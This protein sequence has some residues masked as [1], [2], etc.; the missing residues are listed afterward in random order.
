MANAG[1]GVFSNS[2]NH[3]FEP[4]IPL[5]VPT[6]NPDHIDAIPAQRKKYGYEGFIVT[7][8]NCSST[9]LCVPLKAL[10]DAFGVEKCFVTTLQAVSGS[11]YPGCSSIDMIDNVVPY[12]SGEE[13]KMEI[14]PRKVYIYVCV[15]V[16]LFV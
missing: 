3:R 12:I 10:D 1:L 7:N 5:V 8:A 6:V 2:R 11:G 14:E 15:C 16:C 9:G 4:L 13:E